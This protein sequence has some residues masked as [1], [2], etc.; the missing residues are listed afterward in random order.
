MQEARCLKHSFEVAES[1]CRNC[2]NDFCNECLVYAF[3]PNKH[4]YCV[5]CALAA[6]GVRANA[7]N[8]PAY[9]KRE[10]RRRQKEQRK[11]ERQQKT[12]TKAVASAEID[13]SVPEGSSPDF[14]WAD[15]PVSDDGDK[16]V[17]F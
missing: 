17:S 5:S 7:A 11:L 6:A 15:E 12:A 14:D 3:G 16:V 10:M 9:S 8:R 13:W 4:P 1:C 2:G